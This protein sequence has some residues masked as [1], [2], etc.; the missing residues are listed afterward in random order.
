MD[1]WATCFDSIE[2]SSGPQRLEIQFY[3]VVKCTVG[4]PMLC[5]DNYYVSI[6]DPTVHLTTL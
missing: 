6:G 3:K 4:S 5:C 2:S 1:T